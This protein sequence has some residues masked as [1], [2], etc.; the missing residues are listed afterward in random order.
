MI[1]KG[2]RRRI[3]HAFHQCAETNNKYINDYDK[4]KTHY[5]LC[6]GM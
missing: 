2:I 6:A 5:I 3:C 4:I 1:K